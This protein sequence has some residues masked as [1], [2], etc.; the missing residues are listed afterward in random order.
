MTIPQVLHKIVVY[1]FQNGVEQDKKCAERRAWKKDV[2]VLN[3]LPASVVGDQ[4]A[5]QPEQ[6]VL[7]VPV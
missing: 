6:A 4:A 3:I 5:L 7:T 1:S 2:I